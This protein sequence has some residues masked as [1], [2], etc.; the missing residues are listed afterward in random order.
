MEIMSNRRILYMNFKDLNLSSEVARALEEMGFETPTPIQAQ[1][2]P[3]V[4]EGHDI[5]GQAQTGTGKTAAFGIPLLEKIDPSVRKPQALIL[6]PTRELA[7]QVA[8]EF[9]K[10]GKFLHNVKC[11]PVYGGEPIRFQIMGLRKG[12][13]IIVGTPGRV[14]DHINRKTLKLSHVNT[15]ILDEADEML[16]MGFRED[17]EGILEQVENEEKQMLLFSATMPKPILDITHKFQ[18]NPKLIKVV[19]KEL[20]TK[21]VTQQA[22]HIKS[23][24][25]TEALCRLVDVHQPKLSLVFCNTKRTVD[26]VTDRL[27]QKGYAA[28]KIHGDIDQKLR[29]DVLSKFNRGLINILVATDVAARGIDINDVEAVFNY[30]VPEKEDYYVHR[31][32]RT[33]RAGRK[34]ASYTLVG[35]REGYRLRNIISYTKV[36]IEKSSVP[37]IKKVNKSKI[38]QFKEDLKLSMDN[39]ENLEKYMDVITALENEGYLPNQIAAALLASSMEICEQDEIDFTPSRRSRDDRDSRGRSRDRRGGGDRRERRSSDRGERRER[40]DRGGDSKNMSRLHINLGKTHGIREKD[41][42]GA[43]AGEAQIRGREIGAIDMYDKF[44]FVEIPKEQSTHVLDTMNKSR[45]R[46]KKIR[47]EVANAK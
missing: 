35:E 16:N 40:R 33:G 27:L 32:G 8:N 4:L 5:I 29:L 21:N 24:L 15:V 44:T 43:I 12:V 9:Q 23:A 22:Y 46:G 20:T 11:M 17:I 42:V 34:G 31:I 13:Q 30:D 28:D 2:I 14:I 1:A 3:E 26:E 45:I 37:T 39:N 6:C 36:R 7:V 47:V 19:N 18:K 10:L 25:K 41:I 38:N